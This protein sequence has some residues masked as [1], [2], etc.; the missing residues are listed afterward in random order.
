MVMTVSGTSLY[1]VYRGGDVVIWVGEGLDLYRGNDVVRKGW[2]HDRDD[3][4]IED[5]D[6]M[7]EGVMLYRGKCCYIWEGIIIEEIEGVMLLYRVVVSR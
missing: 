6:V 2:C 5:G 4:V 3:I 1:G 7:I